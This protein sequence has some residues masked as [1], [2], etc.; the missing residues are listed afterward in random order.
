[1]D[2]E[3]GDFENLKE[4]PGPS[5]DEASETPSEVANSKPQLW[6]IQSGKILKTTDVRVSRDQGS[7]GVAGILPP[8]IHGPYNALDLEKPKAPHM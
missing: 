4:S 5:T 1:M 6:D 2:P 7:V 3:E 8:E